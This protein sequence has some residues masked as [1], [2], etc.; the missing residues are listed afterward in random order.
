MLNS[1]VAMALV[2]AIV[3][4]GG[5]AESERPTKMRMAA[6]MVTMS[7]ARCCASCLGAKIECDSSEDHRRAKRSVAYEA[8]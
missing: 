6:V 7:A 8:Q 5:A 2:V 1:V 3:T 4:L